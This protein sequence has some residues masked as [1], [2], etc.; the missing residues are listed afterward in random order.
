MEDI[1]S[2]SFKKKKVKVGIRLRETSDLKSALK[3]DESN[4]S[5]NSISNLKN[6]SANPG[7]IGFFSPKTYDL[8]N[9]EK[10]IS[11]LEERIEEMESYFINK[12]KIY[13]DEYHE[14]ESKLYREIEMLKEQICNKEV[15]NVMLPDECI[16][17]V[18]RY[19]DI[20]SEVCTND[21]NIKNMCDPKL[22][23]VNLGREAQVL[24]DYT[25]NV[26]F[27]QQNIENNLKCIENTLGY[28][29]DS[30]FDSKDK[31]SVHL[32]KKEALE[33][34]DSVEDLQIQLEE[35]RTS[36]LALLLAKQDLKKKILELEAKLNF[37][38][39]QSKDK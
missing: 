7:G 36:Q 5:M 18:R 38:K 2:E 10:K 12:I 6:I 11:K 23:S 24:R 28:T 16:G 29:I 9:A 13:K 17:H 32:L 4:I 25:K 15:S 27:T 19:A 8:L 31:E 20:N 14:K 3:S 1:T 35:S 22:S 37:Y 26:N 34:Y 30:R 39:R 21:K 33:Y